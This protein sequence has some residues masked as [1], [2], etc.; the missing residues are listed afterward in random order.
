MLFLDSS[1]MARNAIFRQLE[2]ECKKNVQLQLMLHL[3][4]GVIL[5]QKMYMH[6]KLQDSLIQ[7]AI[8]LVHKQLQPQ[9][10]KCY[11]T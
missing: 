1:G 7:L 4:Y 9:T 8:L 3:H 2:A 6:V 10:Q 5:L 11:F